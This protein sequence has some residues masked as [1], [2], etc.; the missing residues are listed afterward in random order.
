MKRIITLETKRGTYR[1]TTGDLSVAIATLLPTSPFELS[2]KV[3][4][5]SGLSFEDY[6]GLDIAELLI[7]WCDMNR[8]VS[9]F[10]W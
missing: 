3:S 4:D 9:G 5:Q 6:K 10:N 2:H 8:P 7:I 1:C